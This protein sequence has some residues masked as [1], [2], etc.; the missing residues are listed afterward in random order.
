MC[1]QNVYICRRIGSSAPYF[2]FF[3]EVKSLKSDIEQIVSAYPVYCA[4]LKIAAGQIEVNLDGDNGVDIKVISKIGRAL[5]R[6]L[7]EAELNTQYAALV[8]TTGVGNPL[9]HQWQYKTNVGRNVAIYT[10]AGMSYNALLAGASENDIYL[11]TDKRMMKMNIDDIQKA[12][13][14]I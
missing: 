7:D 6:Y 14:V 4:E 12:K 10:L 5:N 11:K 1:K 8:G 9:V 2:L 13:V 3:T